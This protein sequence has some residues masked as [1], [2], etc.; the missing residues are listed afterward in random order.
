MQQACHRAACSCPPFHVEDGHRLQEV[1]GLCSHIRSPETTGDVWGIPC[2][3]LCNDQL[4]RPW[5]IRI[6][7]EPQTSIS[8]DPGPVTEQRGTQNE[9]AN[10]HRNVLQHTKVWSVN[11][12]RAGSRTPFIPN[13]ARG[14][15]IHG[16]MNTP[17][18]VTSAS[19]SAYCLGK[20]DLPQPAQTP[21]QGAIQRRKKNTSNRRRLR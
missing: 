3:D 10:H 14:F 2:T 5:D 9:L 17:C 16:L 4:F 20:L 6:R 15:S 21:K 19:F 13:S 8:A 12:G 1:L 18:S 11:E 7:G